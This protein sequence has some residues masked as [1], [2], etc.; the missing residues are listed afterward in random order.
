MSIFAL[1]ISSM[2]KSRN[3]ERSPLPYLRKSNK[4][5]VGAHGH[6]LAPLDYL[7]I[8][9]FLRFSNLSHEQFFQSTRRYFVAGRIK[10]VGKVKASTN[11]LLFDCPAPPPT[12]YPESSPQIMRSDTHAVSTPIIAPRLEHIRK[13]KC[14][15]NQT[16]RYWKSSATAVNG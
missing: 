15:A 5:F 6:H 2:D 9:G 3:F 16:G 14:S 1:L 4:R 12:T 7:A 10:A 13:I 11:A 8:S